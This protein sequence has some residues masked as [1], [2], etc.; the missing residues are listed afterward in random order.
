MTRFTLT[1]GKVIVKPFNKIWIVLFVILIIVVVL[2]QYIY[3]PEYLTLAEIWPFLKKMFS[4]RNDIFGHRTWGDYFNYIFTIIPY[5]LLKTIKM[6]IGGTVIGSAIALPFS[7]LAAKNVFKN[8]WITSPFRFIMNII[9]TIPAAVMV[10]VAVFI[11]GTGNLAGIIGFSLFSFGIMAKM[12]YEVIET[13]DMNSFEALEST[14]AN[15]TQAFRYAL[16][17]QIF[18]IFI[19]YLIYVFEINIRASAL[20]AFVGVESIGSIIQVGLDGGDFDY[21][22]G[23]VIVLTFVIIIIQ[24]FSN[25]IRGK[26]Q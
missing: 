22:G 26:L 5:Y 1:S 12:L 8:K 10:I 4:P 15:K 13:S 3:F 16:L 25:W 11:V 18:P 7:V 9:R 19:S 6:S 17:P 24:L 20:L 14:G 21:I 23:V 2:G